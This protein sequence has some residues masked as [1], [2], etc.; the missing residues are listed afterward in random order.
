MRRRGIVA[1]VAA[2]F[3]APRS[4]RGDSTRVLRFLPRADPGSLDPIADPR[5]EVVDA[6][7]LVWDTLYGVD[8]RLEPQPQ[9]CAGHEASDDRREWTFH[10]RPGLR[11]HD[12]S[13]VL[14]RDAVASLRRWMTR[15]RMGVA[16]GDR[17]DALDVLDD[18][19]FRFRL[20]TP[21]GPMLYALGKCSPPLAVIMPERLANTDPAMPVA[22]VVGSGPLWL[23]ADEWRP[24]SRV[25]FERVPDY[26]VR[27]EAADWLAGGKQ[28]LFDRIEWTFLPDPA[29]AA[30]A[31]QNGDA[32]WWTAPTADLVPLLKRNRNMLVDIADPLGR[33]GVL[34]FNRARPPFDDVRVRR[35]VLLSLGQEAC[36]AAMT[37]GD[38]ALS[39]PMPGV[40]TPGTQ[41]STASGDMPVGATVPG[42]L[43]AARRLV[44]EAAAADARVVVLAR[45]QEVGARAQ[46]NV[47]AGLLQRLGLAGEVQVLADVGEAS[48]VPDGWGAF[49]TFSDGADAATPASAALDDGA[50][51][52]FRQARSDWYAATTPAAS[53]AALAA[54]NRAALADVAFVPT[55]QF[56][57]YQAWRTTLSGIVK[58]PFPM[59]WGVQKT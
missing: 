13:P 17:L 18:R 33:V 10:L 34:R 37:G 49:V 2:V 15:D 42:D 53:A 41:A 48:R 44:Q 7:L 55:G 19:S 29:Q 11:F 16:I 52:A 50:A 46:A 45:T 39:R 54:V 51:D 8:Q 5:P 24:G 25:V 28:M 31:L 30:E 1:A 35:A 9:M 58:A 47:V 23:R 59:V 26:A 40:F 36:M 20:H 43:D 38:D 3:V 32:D 14:A 22:Q 4:G 57:R 6:A 27:S 12:G 21:F 56:L